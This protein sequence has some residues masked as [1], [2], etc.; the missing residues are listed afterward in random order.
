MV[1]IGSGDVLGGASIQEGKTEPEAIDASPAA[2]VP[3]EERAT[4]GYQW[5]PLRPSAVGEDE[6]NTSQPSYPPNSDMNT[7]TNRV[8]QTAPPRWSHANTNPPPPERSQPDGRDGP[9]LNRP[10]WLTNAIVSTQHITPNSSLSYTTTGSAASSQDGDGDVSAHNDTATPLEIIT[11]S[12]PPVAKGRRLIGELKRG[13]ATHL[14]SDSDTESPV[15]K[16]LGPNFLAVQ[17][18]LERL[19]KDRI[20]DRISE[21]TG[22]PSAA[23]DGLSSGASASAGTSPTDSSEHVHGNNTAETSKTPSFTD[24]NFASDWRSA[25]ENSDDDLAPFSSRTSDTPSAQDVGTNQG[26][27]YSRGQSQ[28]GLDPR[29]AWEKSSQD[30]SGE[31]AIG[32]VPVDNL[33]FPVR[34]RSV[35]VESSRPVSDGDTPR[36][37]NPTAVEK[38]G[39]STASSRDH[40]E[41][42]RGIHHGKIHSSGGDR[43][44]SSDDTDELL[45][46]E[47][48]LEGDRHY[49]LLQR[50]SNLSDSRHPGGAHDSYEAGLP[51]SASTDLESGGGTAKKSDHKGPQ[52]LQTQTKVEAEEHALE[53]S[54]IRSLHWSL[55]AGTVSP[56]STVSLAQGDSQL[57]HKE[58]SVGHSG[59]QDSIQEQSLSSEYESVAS[60]DDYRDVVAR[61]HGA[62]LTASDVS[63][64][65][66]DLCRPVL[67]GDISERRAASRDGSLPR[68]VSYGIYDIR[69]S[70]GPG[71]TNRRRRAMGLQPRPV[72]EAITKEAQGAVYISGS[73]TSSSVHGII[74][75]GGLGRDDFATHGIAYDM[76]PPSRTNSEKHSVRNSKIKELEQTKQSTSLD[77]AEIRDDFEGVRG[78]GR[79][80]FPTEDQISVSSDGRQSRDLQMTSRVSD[81]TREGD[82]LLENYDRKRAKHPRD[83][84]HSRDSEHPLDSAHPRDFAHP[85]DSELPSHQQG[86]L[87]KKSRTRKHNLGKQVVAKSPH[88]SL[89][90]RS[91]KSSQ[92]ESNISKLSSLLSG[93]TDENLS[94]SSLSSLVPHLKRSTS[95]RKKSNMS[96]TSD[97]SDVYEHFN[98]AFVQPRHGHAIEKQIRLRELL[99]SFRSRSIPQIV[100]R[101]H[102]SSTESTSCL[103]STGTVETPSPSVPNPRAHGEMER[104]LCSTPPAPVSAKCLC[105]CSQS[106]VPK[107][108]F[109]AQTNQHT[110]NIDSRLELTIP[111]T[112]D[113]G[114]NFPTPVVARTQTN[115]SRGQLE[116][117]STQTDDRDPNK[118]RFSGPEDKREIDRE[119][120]TVK[121][122]TINAK[123]QVEKR[124]VICQSSPKKS[125]QMSNLAIHGLGQQTPKERLIPSQNSPDHVRRRSSDRTNRNQFPV[126]FY[127]VTAKTGTETRTGERQTSP[128]SQT[129]DK[130][131]VDVFEDKL[132]SSRHALEKLTLQEAFL[133]AKP[134]FV[135]RSQ[136]RAARAE[137]AAVRKKNKERRIAESLAEREE[138]T[139]HKTGISALAT[140]NR[141]S[142]TTTS[143]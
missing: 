77:D 41:S 133:F 27:K 34:R 30:N 132:D 102:S 15:S 57:P 54:D 71:S 113:V 43:S 67:R 103:S 10:A 11:S 6:G 96:S 79:G 61:G 89:E 140:A 121:R 94:S 134:Q 80:S 65:S 64:T 48:V 68:A 20:T 37:S 14:N 83:S 72:R 122:E 105:T 116:D 126:W 5:F 21:E 53:D 74:S 135:Q 55:G 129:I 63:S 87:G 85:L 2:D 62:R 138:K 25:R 8:T 49:L 17:Q 12:V 78:G 50:K 7:S 1:L 19:K 35:P 39:Y 46:Y 52:S 111:A 136:K 109:P 60:R 91:S 42:G 137:Q 9:D 4:P 119:A 99:K 82:G 97:S 110:T 28:S 128:S 108:A 130:L 24:N 117:A 40:R 115:R 118:Q 139:A 23:E 86:R 29:I 38:S 123:R 76:T 59:G 45:T 98:S 124:A 142:K 18:V 101:R 58:E 106:T 13:R 56:I 107:K 44:A 22:T 112:R 104:G 93:S 32:P 3:A 47:P 31:V 88:H 66:D 16:L 131:R 114:V 69:R 92:I 51:W 75:G 95:H 143:G 90:Q 84:E 26:V 120:N 70:S 81:G 36:L 100:W 73:S 33:N 141:K 125:E 127:P